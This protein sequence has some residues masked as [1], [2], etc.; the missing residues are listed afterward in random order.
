MVHMAFGVFF[1][2]VAVQLLAAMAEHTKARQV[3]KPILMPLLLLFYWLKADVP[4][5]LVMLALVTSTMGDI[6][7]LWPEKQVTFVAGLL[8]FLTAHA[9]YIVVFTGS[10]ALANGLPVWFYLAA[11]PYLLYCTGLFLM[12]RPYLGP[13]KA[14][15]VLY[16]AAIAA[17]SLI[18]L[19][20][21]PSFSG[22]GFYMPFIGSLLFVVS[23]SIL[24]VDTFRSKIP[25]GDVYIMSTYITAQVLIVAGMTIS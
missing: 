6:F 23:D 9:L 20:R 21:T 24:A 10:T 22:A 14:P 18:S 17:M 1:G 11:V 25:R 12:L 8:S 13:M 15:F 3:T 19:L 7:L 4:A 16:S 2:A 5:V